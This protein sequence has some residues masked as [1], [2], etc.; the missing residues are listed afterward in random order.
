M[1]GSSE[2]LKIVFV[3]E[4]HLLVADGKEVALPRSDTPKIHAFIDGSVIEII[5]CE[6]V[7]YTKRFYYSGETAP[8]ITIRASGQDLAL[9]AWELSPISADRLTTVD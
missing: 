4:R 9:N 6:R 1:L 3:P 8:D 5:F 2:L 7:G